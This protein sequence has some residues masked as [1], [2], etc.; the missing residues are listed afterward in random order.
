[1]AIIAV[2]LIPVI[3]ILIPMAVARYMEK[4]YFNN[5]ICPRCGR[6]LEYT[7]ADHQGGRLWECMDYNCGYFTWV[8]YDGVD[9]D[10]RR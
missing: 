9:K 10:F 6:P 5:G 2:I 1:M 4:V 3:I 8:T 7:K